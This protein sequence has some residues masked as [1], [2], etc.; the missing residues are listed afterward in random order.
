MPGSL[1]ELRCPGCRSLH[2]LTTGANWCAEHG[3]AWGYAQLECHSCQRLISVPAG[4][5]HDA[6]SACPRCS[7]VLE[8]WAGRVWH[9]R[10]AEGYVGEERLRGPCPRCD[11]ELTENNSEVIGLW[12]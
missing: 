12:D 5:C 10:T 2:K 8:A 4:C 1:F 11:H 3:D 9:E 6:P 7:G